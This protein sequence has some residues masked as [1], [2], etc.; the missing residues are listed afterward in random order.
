MY[1]Y[2]FAWTHINWLST[3]DRYFSKTEIQYFSTNITTKNLTWFYGIINVLVRKMP[4]S[5]LA[6]DKPILI[7]LITPRGAILVENRP[8]SR[9]VRRL[10][11]LLGNFLYTI[12]S[13]TDFKYIIIMI[14]HNEIH[15]EISFL[16]GLSKCVNK[17]ICIF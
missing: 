3:G 17:S 16:F 7:W 6:N 13:L 15:N 11:I 9:S 8:V 5:V 4:S 12:Y 14:N 1:E 10:N 2:A